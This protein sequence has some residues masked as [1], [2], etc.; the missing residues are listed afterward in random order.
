MSNEAKQRKDVRTQAATAGRYWLPT[1]PY[2]LVDAVNRMASATGS[3]RYAQ[4][5]ANADY[6]GHNVTVYY[7]DYKGYF[8]CEH[9]FG[10]RVVHARSY[11][12]ADAL[13]AGRRE[14]D[15]GHRGTSVTTCDLTPAEAE[16]ALSLGY[17][18][19]SKEGEEAWNALWFSELHGMVNEAMPDRYRPDTI[20][21]LLQAT[22]AVDYRERKERDFAKQLFT[23]EVK[24]CRIT[25]PAGERGMVLSG[26]HRAT[27]KPYATVMVDGRDCSSGDV[28]EAR[29]WWKGQLAKGWK[30]VQA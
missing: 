30:A 27:G 9:Y 20:H 21:L 10:E 14:Y 29:K 24:E 13:R 6:N 19:H 23:G 18:P 25:G 7:N 12:V 11:D 28:T 26:K 5:S 22:D 4:L 2:T 8:L 17:I 1:R 15:M 3:V 16:V